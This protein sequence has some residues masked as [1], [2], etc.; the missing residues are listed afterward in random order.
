MPRRNSNVRTKNPRRPKT[1]DDAGKF[2]ASKL[3]ESA[4]RTPPTHHWQDDPVCLTHPELLINASRIKRHTDF[5][6]A[7]QLSDGPET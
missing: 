3:T 6:F 4:R 1:K 7:D 5:V 2:G